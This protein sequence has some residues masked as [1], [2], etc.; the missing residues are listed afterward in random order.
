MKPKEKTHPFD[1]FAII[2]NGEKAIFING[3]LKLVNLTE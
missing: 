2:I 3:I 1:G